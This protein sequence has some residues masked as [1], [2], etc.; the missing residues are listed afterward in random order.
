MPL[1]MQ[2]KRLRSRSMVDLTA[3]AKNATERLAR[4][5]KDRGESG[6]PARRGWSGSSRFDVKAGAGRELAPIA[7]RLPPV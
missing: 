4:Y 6:E 7:D 2:W 5:R 1:F 3:W